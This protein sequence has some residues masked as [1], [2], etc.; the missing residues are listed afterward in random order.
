MI[1]SDS[2]VLSQIPWILAFFVLFRIL[3]HLLRFWI[4]SDSLELFLDFITFFCF[5]PALVLPLRIFW[6]ISY[7]FKFSSFLSDSLEFSGDFLGF[8]GFFDI[9]LYSVLSNSHEFSIILSYF[10]EFLLDSRVF[11]HSLIFCPNFPIFFR[12][13]PDSL[14]HIFSEFGRILSNC[15]GFFSYSCGFYWILSNYIRILSDSFEFSRFLSEYFE[16]SCILSNSSD[17]SRTLEFSRILSYLFEFLPDSLGFFR[18]LSDFFRILSYSFRF[19]LNYF[20]SFGFSSIFPNP[21]DSGIFCIFSDSLSSS[22]ILDSVGFSRIIFEFYHILLVSSSS[23][24]SFEN[25]LNYLV[26]FRILQFSLG[27]SWIFWG[28]SWIFPL[29]WHSSLF[30]SIKFSRILR[31]SFLFF[32]ISSGLSGFF[33]ISHILS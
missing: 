7:F 14:S 9:L 19:F 26:F 15:L 4:L 8:F 20:D 3:S 18:I 27:F 11:S 10:F 29:F 6:I 30:G 1:L 32:R 22:Q 5:I 17:F 12:I 21:L 25:V 24:T 2:L 33:A 28:F 16:F 23:R 31:N 13:L